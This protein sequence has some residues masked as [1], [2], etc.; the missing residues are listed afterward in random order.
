MTR[1]HADDREQQVRRAVR[2]YIKV[3]YDHDVAFACKG[4]SVNR[5]PSRG[6]AW[7]RALVNM[8]P[9]QVRAMFYK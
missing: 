5:Y 4:F 8:S 7:L 1:S 2:P 3:D 9:I 6:Q